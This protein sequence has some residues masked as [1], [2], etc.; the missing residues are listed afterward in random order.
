EVG[1]RRR[2]AFALLKVE[3]S[4]A[5]VAEASRQARAA[6]DWNRLSVVRE[7]DAAAEEQDRVGL[8]SARQS[9]AAEDD[10][11]ALPELEDPGVLQEEI[12][13]LGKEETE[14]REVHLLL[15]GFDLREVGVDG[16][17]PRQPARHAVL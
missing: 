6:A 7:P 9:S 12:A 13:L 17:V 14:P 1:S 2:G 3:R 11:A 4:D 8:P 15:V 16:E 10:A 5:V